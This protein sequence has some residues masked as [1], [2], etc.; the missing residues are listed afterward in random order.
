MTISLQW[1]NYP[2]ARTLKIRI[3]AAEGVT[4]TVHS[5][6][7]RLAYTAFAIYAGLSG[8]AFAHEEA[9]FP[10]PTREAPIVVDASEEESSRGNLIYVI[11]GAGVLAG[12]IAIGLSARRKP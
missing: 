6:I 3:C 5:M 8:T 10:P 4:G 12:G 9:P 7:T 11:G 2:S 1:R